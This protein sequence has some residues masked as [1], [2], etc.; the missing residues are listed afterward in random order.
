MQRID[1]TDNIP[2][3][4]TPETTVAPGFFRRPSTVSGAQGT[5][6]TG[7]WAND[8]QETIVNPIE[9]AGISLV[10][11][12]PT[13]LTAAI[14]VLAGL[15]ADQAEANAAADLAAHAASI[16]D[17][18]TL[19]HLE[20]ATVGE[21]A[22]LANN[23]RALTPANLRNAFA[24]NAEAKGHLVIPTMYNLTGIDLILNWGSTPVV[25]TVS[26]L[27]SRPYTALHLFAMGGV[28]RGLSQADGTHGG[29][30]P[31]PLDPLT[32]IQVNSSFTVDVNWI[33]I[34]F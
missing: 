26:D 13:Q 19:G 9:A 27:L 2:S 6:V 33:S 17:P 21:V 25:G 12:N 30:Q 11:G 15:L 22:N 1:T 10:K 4:E 3:P 16:S 31:D 14:N 18:D 5:T 7:D 8:V 29:A 23:S 24:L 32:S 20:V 28:F 34:G